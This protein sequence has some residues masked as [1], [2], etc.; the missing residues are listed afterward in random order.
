M[1]EQQLGSAVPVEGRNVSRG[2][3]ALSITRATGCS[4][5]TAFSSFGPLTL[6]SNRKCGSHKLLKPRTICTA[7]KV[8]K[9]ASVVATPGMPPTGVNPTMLVARRRGAKERLPISTTKEALEILWR[10]AYCHNEKSR[11]P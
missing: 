5:L 7:I 10:L 1:T 6:R 2:L 8:I 3:I 11:R 9:T 4:F